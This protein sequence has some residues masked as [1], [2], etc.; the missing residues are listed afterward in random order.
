MQV[1]LQR[2]QVYANLSP[3]PPRFHFTC[4]YALRQCARFSTS[5]DIA[6]EVFGIVLLLLL[7]MMVI[8]KY[9][10]WRCKCSDVEEEDEDGNIK[11]SRF[12]QYNS[13]FLNLSLHQYTISNTSQNP[14]HQ[15]SITHHRTQ[16]TRP[17]YSLRNAFSNTRIRRPLSIT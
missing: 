15:L 16:L 1:F 3:L 8:F 5:Y 9:I 2:Y 10:P 6:V 11:V 14:Y 13:P 12:S 7:M 4:D 17:S